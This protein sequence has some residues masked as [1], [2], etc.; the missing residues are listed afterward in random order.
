MSLRSDSMERTL[1]RLSLELL[2]APAQRKTN[3]EVDAAKLHL[4]S[5]GG[6]HSSPRNLAK[7]PHNLEAAGERGTQRRETILRLPNPPLRIHDSQHTLRYKA[8]RGGRLRT[9]RPPPRSSMLA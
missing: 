5:L 6:R 3:S 9:A 2:K 4:A 8:A 7:A 1:F